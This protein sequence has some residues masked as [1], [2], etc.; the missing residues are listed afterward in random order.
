M[1]SLS[2]LFARIR[3]RNP[4]GPD[5]QPTSGAWSVSV[6]LNPIALTLDDELELGLERLRLVSMGSVTVRYPPGQLMSVDFDAV[7]Q[8]DALRGA[9]IAE[10]MH[11]VR[12]PKRRLRAPALARHAHSGATVR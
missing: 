3:Q 1:K 9:V 8:L 2:R 4:S 7:D 5:G 12:S 11:G 6:G 10:R